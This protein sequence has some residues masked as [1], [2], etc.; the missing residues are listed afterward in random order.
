MK[1]SK[2]KIAAEEAK[3]WEDDADDVLKMLNN[4]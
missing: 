4:I 1:D 2:K 3:E